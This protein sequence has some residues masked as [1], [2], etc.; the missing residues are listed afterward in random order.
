MHIR[1]KEKGFSLVELAIV[2]MIV[3][4]LFA[5]GLKMLGPM[6]QRL[7]HTDTK[8]TLKASYEAVIGY[9]ATHD[10]LP[11]VAEFKDLAIASKDVW[12]NEIIYRPADE[13][14]V[15]NTVCERST[16][17]LYV[18][19]NNTGCTSA[20]DVDNVAFFLFSRGANLNI[21][22][23]VFDA[24]ATSVASATIQTYT[25]DYMNTDNSGVD[26]F[27]G[28]ALWPDPVGLR[29]EQYK[30]IVKWITLVDLRTK[31]G[32][33]GAELK[34]SNNKLNGCDNN[35]EYSD[36][37]FADGGIPFSSGGKYKWCREESSYSGLAFKA[38]DLSA[39]PI[40]V[41][42]NDLADDTDGCENES[43]DGG[44]WIQSD[45]IV[46]SGRPNKDPDSYKYK[47][48][49]RDNNDP[50]VNG[51]DKITSKSFVL[52]ID[53]SCTS[54]DVANKTGIEYR[55]KKNSGNCT[56]W[57]VGEIMN[58]VYGQTAHI[59]SALGCIDVPCDKTY[60]DFSAED[61]DL[62]GIVKMTD[63]TAGTPS[64]CTI[65]DY[66]DE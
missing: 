6:V 60:G 14:T 27:A 16:T 11:T 54:V 38:D 43:E 29:K 41:T 53:A 42:V 1:N 10:R 49:V 25:P 37:I 63:W 28:S 30:D 44:N 48:Y 18:C 59:Y 51:R 24:S 31:A 19:D 17:D 2:M 62:N 57:G 9:A 34:I 33:M 3:G 52:S 4:L 64:T 58:I 66:T 32:C 50:V 36:R 22:T 15:D 61:T 46:I 35:L 65:V 55:F 13:L 45:S 39:T 40:P 20:T 21:Q 5:L 12:G 8:E 26:D 47:F 23:D 56:T 7:K